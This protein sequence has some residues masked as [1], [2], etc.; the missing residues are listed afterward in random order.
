VSKKDKLIAKAKNNPGGLRF[1][2]ACKL[3]EYF[4]FVQTG[5]KGSHRVYA[6]VDVLEI[7]NLQSKKD[8]KAKRYQVEQ[9]L[10][11]VEGYSL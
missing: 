9:I 8:G 7:V 5:G 11:L 1:E 4:G 2:E 3:A 10:E 6:R